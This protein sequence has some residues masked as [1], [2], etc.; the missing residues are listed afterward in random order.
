MAAELLNRVR[1][2][3]V[4][5]AIATGFGHTNVEPHRRVETGL[6]RQHQVSEFIAEVLSV[7]RR[8]EIALIAAPIRNRVDHAMDQLAYA[9]LPF[10]GANLA[11]KILTNYNVCSSLRPIFGNLD[12][13]LF[14]DDGTLIVADAGGAHFPAHTFIR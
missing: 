5:P 9:G 7:F 6:L 12:I 3:I 13:A 2:G 4:I 8:L 1:I 10:R 11:V 14:E